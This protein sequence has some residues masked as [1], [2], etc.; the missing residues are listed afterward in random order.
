M[1]LIIY[2]FLFLP[3]FSIGQITFFKSYGGAGNDY[4][5]SIVTTIDTSYTIVG[6]TESFGNGDTDMYLFN[7]DSLGTL[8]WSK[9]YGGNNL[10]WGMD[11]KQT[12][13]TGYILCGYSNSYS[14]DYDVFVV[15]TDKNGDSLWTKT[16]GGSDWDFANSVATT[17]DTGYII[18]GETYSYGTGTSDGYVIKLDS[19][20]DT[21]WTKSFGGAGKD[22]FNDV[23]ETY[24]GDL[25]FAGGTTSVDG[26]TDFWLVK[27]DNLG[28]EIW[29]YTAGDSLNEVINS[30]VELIDSNY[31]FIG[32]KES[33]TGTNLVM[34]YHK[35]NKNGNYHYGNNYDQPL[36]ETGDFILQYTNETDVIIGGSINS[37]GNGGYDVIN[38]KL[39]EWGFGSLFSNDGT[40]QDD[41]TEQADTTADNSIVIVGTTEGSANGIKSVFVM[42]TDSTLNAPSTLNDIFDVTSIAT[43]NNEKLFE[44][45]PNPS[46]EAI[47]IKGSDKLI[48]QPYSIYTILGDLIQFGNV[49]EGT[50]NIYALKTGIYFLSFPETPSKPIKFTKI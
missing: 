44:I 13:D 47:H 11:L 10:D 37:T 5:K 42:K 20:G 7:I 15:K 26:D 22:F 41:I 23:I 1:K 46:S 12:I 48:N 3:I 19:L 50:I 25:L 29:Q 40:N 34:D 4:G 2:I 18:A 14:W 30:V 27:T 31:Y 36:N 24:N 21:L 28:N 49:S 32:D 8:K 16:Y 39:N 38:I 35:I 43:P 6:A 17:Q 45:F 33:I 9:T